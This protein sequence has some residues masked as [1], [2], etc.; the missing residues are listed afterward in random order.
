MKKLIGIFCKYFILNEKKKIKSWKIWYQKVLK[1]S[2][3]L[4]RGGFRVLVRGVRGVERSKPKFFGTTLP[5]GAIFYRAE[6]TINPQTY[7]QRADIWLTYCY[8]SSSQDISLPIYQ[9]IAPIHFN[10]H[11]K[12]HLSNRSPSNCLWYDLLTLFWF[13]IPTTIKDLCTVFFMNTG[14]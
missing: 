5:G 6:P 12:E 4:N 1:K 9:H 7:K 10:F 2:S 11:L 13:K 8:T 3:D 14:T